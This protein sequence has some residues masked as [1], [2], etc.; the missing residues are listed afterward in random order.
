MIIDSAKRK[1]TSKFHL[2][3]SCVHMKIRIMEVTFS[4]DS[5]SKFVFRTIIPL[6]NLLPYFMT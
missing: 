6:W 1:N 2:G 5:Q 3:R 4:K